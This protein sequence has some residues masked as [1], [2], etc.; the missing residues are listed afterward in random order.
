MIWATD[1]AP[2]PARL[3]GKRFTRADSGHEVVMTD[4]SRR[5]AAGLATAERT[6]ANVRE[7]VSV[8]KGGDA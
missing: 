7:D 1:E 2:G 6:I 4:P 5:V 3:A 8:L